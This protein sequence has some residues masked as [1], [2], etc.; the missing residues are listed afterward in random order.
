MYDCHVHSNFSM[1]SKTF[2]EEL[3][4]RSIEI[5][6]D[7]L[8]ITDHLDCD[9]PGYSFYVDLEEYDKALNNLRERYSNKLKVLKGIEVGIQP[10]VI[11]DTK[12]ILRGHKFDY[13][14]GSVH[15]VDGKDPY[16]DGY[17]DGKSAYETYQSYLEEI[18]FMLTHYD[19]F[20]VLGHID[21]I[22]RYA[23][24]DVRTLRYAN[25]MDIIDSILSHLVKNNKGIELNTRSYIPKPGRTDCVPDIAIFK[26]FK[27]LGGEMVCL[28][29]DSHQVEFI[30]YRF[31]EYADLLSKAGF[32]YLTHFENR[33]PHFIPI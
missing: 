27:E 32:K 28:G 21:Y 7:G 16:I 12:A 25:H 18:Y 5:G 6:L 4:R 26:R 19:D 31:D 33:I 17:Y 11:D 13:I 20:D 23:Y 22:V 3:V 15:I 10:D 9:Y 2:P 24:Y 1:D 8:A 29:S 30:G 14:I